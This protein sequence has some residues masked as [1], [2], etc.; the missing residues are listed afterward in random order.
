MTPRLSVCCSSFP[1]QGAV[2]KGG[3]NILLMLCLI[4]NSPYLQELSSFSEDCRQKRV[5]SFT[6]LLLSSLLW[7]LIKTPTLSGG[8]YNL[9]FNAG[10]I[11][12][13]V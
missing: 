6:L 1:L 11:N 10:S 5:N 13:L 3:E 4:N 9:H 7:F 8:K 12:N 2:D